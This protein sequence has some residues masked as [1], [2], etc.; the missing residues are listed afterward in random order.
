LVLTLVEGVPETN[1]ELPAAK[2]EVSGGEI[3]KE[4]QGMVGFKAFQPGFSSRFL[5]VYFSR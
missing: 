5:W 1:P 4:E 2:L 3:S